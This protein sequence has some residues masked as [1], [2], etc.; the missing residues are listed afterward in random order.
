MIAPEYNK[1]E[2][3]AY[4]NRGKELLRKGKPAEAVKELLVAD[5]M[6]PNHDGLLN[7]LGMAYFRLEEHDKAEKIYLKLLTTNPDVHILHTN[8]GLIYFKENRLDEAEKHLSRAGEI[9]PSHLKTKSYLGLVYQKQGKLEEALLKFKEA[10]SDKMIEAVEKELKNGKT[11]K[12]DKTV[13]EQDKIEKDNLSLQSGKAVSGQSENIVSTIFE[14]KEKTEPVHF[15]PEDKKDILNEMYHIKAPAVE[16]FEAIIDICSPGDKDKIPEAFKFIDETTIEVAL[17]HEFFIQH[18]CSFIMVGKGKCQVAEFSSRFTRCSGEG[19]IVLGGG[20]DKCLYFVYVKVSEL[21]LALNSVVLISEGFEPFV[22]KTYD[23]DFI[24]IS[25][26]GYVVLR[27][28]KGLAHFTI[29]EDES[30]FVPPELVLGYSSPNVEGAGK[31]EE[32]RLI[33]R[34]RQVLRIK[35]KGA[36]IVGRP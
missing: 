3:L 21:C 16:E 5:S 13:L 25:G 27:A 4:V 36:V 17:M 8:L 24:H 35:G 28:M 10:G 12:S 7:L 34:N 20:E 9:N 14:K 18:K 29:K 33:A 6:K 26:E 19:Q 23:R 15:I 22:V 11:G 2:F 31:S 1:S 32:S 30:A